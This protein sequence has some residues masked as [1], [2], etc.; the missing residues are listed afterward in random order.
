MKEQMNF[1]SFFYQKCPRPLSKVLFAAILFG[2][3]HN[4]IMTRENDLTVFSRCHIDIKGNDTI[5]D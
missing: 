3:L 2:F 5:G 1:L 4:D